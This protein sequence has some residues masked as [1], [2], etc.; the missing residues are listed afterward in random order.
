MTIFMARRITDTEWWTNAE[1]CI[2][3]NTPSRKH[4]QDNWN[5]IALM[6]DH[7]KML[8]GGDEAGWWHGPCAV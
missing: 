2:H 5:G 8:A 7:V 4:A 1:T 6:S 3:V